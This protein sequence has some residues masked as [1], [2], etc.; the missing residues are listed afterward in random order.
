MSN[1]GYLIGARGI[2]EARCA[3]AVEFRVCCFNAEEETV[4]GRA[5]ETRNI[6]DG[7]IRKRQSIEE[8]HAERGSQ[9]SKE[10]GALEG[11]WNKH[12][13]AD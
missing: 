8:Q 12:R 9:S 7:V 6:K 1:F 4:L 2:E 5:C 3:F 10:N 11:D 13:S